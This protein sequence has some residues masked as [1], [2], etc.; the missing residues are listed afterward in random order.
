M[1]SDP[2]ISKELVETIIEAA[3]WA[4][5]HHL[6]EPW[7]FVVMT[8]DGRRKLGEAMSTALSLSAGGM[9]QERLDAER[10]KP[11]GASVIIALINSPKIGPN[12]VPQEEIVAAG[13]ALQNMLLAAHS[14]GLG[15]MVRTGLHAY[16]EVVRKFFQLNEQESVV[17]LVYLGHIAEPPPPGRR[18]GIAGKVEWRET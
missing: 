8:G 4:P 9:T 17:G 1:L 15:S 7:R 6:T 5:N 2:P 12:F 18:G 3:I 14:L 11:L 16:S 10:N 13:A